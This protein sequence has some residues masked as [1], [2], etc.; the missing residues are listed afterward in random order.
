MRYRKEI[1]AELNIRFKFVSAEY[2][3]VRQPPNDFLQIIKDSPEQAAAVKFSTGEAIRKLGADNPLLNYFIP[4]FSVGCRRTTPGNG[5]LEALTKDNVRTVTE[6][7]VEITPEGVKTT[8]GKF[9]KVDILICATGFDMSFCPRYSLVGQNG[10]QLSQQWAKKP[11][12]YMSMAVPNFP[13]HFSE[14]TAHKS[15]CV[16]VPL[17][18]IKS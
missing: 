5:Y 7:I 18:Q 16:V 1:E 6:Q 8:T 15:A 14:L 2:I 10:L 9:V 17:D 11:E 12:A 13:N 3:V 4:D